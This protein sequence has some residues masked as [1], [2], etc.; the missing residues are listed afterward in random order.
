[1][2]T[3]SNPVRATRGFTPVNEILHPHEKIGGNHGNTSRTHDF[4]EFIDKCHLLELESFGLPF[5]WFNKS[6]SS[7]IWKAG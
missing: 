6:D 2:V 3:G 1:M 4:A 5:T 7:S